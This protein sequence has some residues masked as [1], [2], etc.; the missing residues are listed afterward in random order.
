VI[1]MTEKPARS[2]WHTGVTATITCL[3]LLSCLGGAA[4]LGVSALVAAAIVS[5]IVGCLVAAV[6]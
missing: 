6:H 5:P 4:G 1:A 3:V 2:R